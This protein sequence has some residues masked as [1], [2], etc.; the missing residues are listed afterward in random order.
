LR[1]ASQNP[2]VIEYY[3]DT[4]YMD[5]DYN[6]ANA[7]TFVFWPNPSFGDSPWHSMAMGNLAEAAKTLAYT[8]DK[9][10]ALGVDWTNFIGG[11]SLEILRNFLDQAL[12]QKLIP[13]APTLGSY[14]TADE[15]ATRYANLKAWY[16]AHQNFWVG[17]GPYYLDKAMLVEKTATLKSNPDYV[18]PQDK[19]MRFSEPRVPDA[20]I[21]ASGDVTAGKAA[22][23]DV[24]VTFKGQPYP[25]GDIQ[26]V[27]YLLFDSTGTI[28]SSGDA[29][30]VSDGQYRVSLS[31]TETAKLQTGSAKL[32]VVV[33][34]IPV[35]LPTLVDYIVSVK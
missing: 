19:W 18:D 6:V 16:Q 25:S 11:P 27:K 33:L 12:A 20:E 10:D 15:A 31:G 22:D 1:I 23:F 4:W 24:T 13:Y 5:A 30:N 8:T 29:T 17:T 34:A 21:E 35:A 3:T 2:L 26:E 28:V 7:Y 9:A 32:E 14:I